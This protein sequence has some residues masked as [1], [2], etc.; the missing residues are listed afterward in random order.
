MALVAYRANT[1]DISKENLNKEIPMKKVFVGMI[2]AVLTPC[3]FAQGTVNVSAIERAAKAGQ[4]KQAARVA[5]SEKQVMDAWQ[6]FKKQAGR[7][8]Y[9]DYSFMFL[10]LDGVRQAYM[11]LRTKSPA[12]ARKCAAEL[13]KPVSIADGKRSIKVVSYVNMESCNLW[14]NEQAKF[15]VFARALQEDAEAAQAEKAA[16]LLPMDF[17]QAV[18]S[19]R[20]FVKGSKELNASWTIQSLMPAMDAFNRHV[21]QNPALG[22]A[23][24]KEIQQPIQAGWG[25]QVV[26][27][28]FIRHHSTEVYTMQYELDA[29]AHQL[30]QLSK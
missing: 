20:Q 19:F 8:N 4:T 17:K 29:F 16:A 3:L 10:S 27:S 5:A 23:M 9:Y 2:F 30:E 28:D 26:A 24:A 12:A 1:Y 7:L 13:V 22:A 18:V 14:Q 11:N 6:Q 15:D 25:G 21:K